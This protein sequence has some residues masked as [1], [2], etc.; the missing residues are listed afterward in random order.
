MIELTILGSA[1]MALNIEERIR[2]WAKEKQHLCTQVGARRSSTPDKQGNGLF[3]IRVE[4]V[5]DEEKKTIE[6]IVS[7]H[8]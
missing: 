3:Q 5:P 8:S 4:G 6:N 1:D 7:S 2:N